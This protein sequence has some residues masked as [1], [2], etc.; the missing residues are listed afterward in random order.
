MHAETGSQFKVDGTFGWACYLLLALFGCALVARAQERAAD[1]RGLLVPILAV[2]PYALVL[3]WLAGDT[4]LVA[5]R[6]V[7]PFIDATAPSRK[8]LDLRREALT[9]GAINARLVQQGER[10]C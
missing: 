5:A 4:A 3:F 2:A 6:P 9:V 10:M 1:T 8:P 7:N